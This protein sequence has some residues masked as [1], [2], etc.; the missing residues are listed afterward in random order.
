MR[1][2]TKLAI[3]AAAAAGGL[4]LAATAARAEIVCNQAGDC[5]HVRHHYNYEPSFGLMV[6]PDRWRWRDEDR[7]HYRWREH[8]GRGYWGPNGVWIRF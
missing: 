7:D 2:A 1:L 6:H 3:V 8:S 5:W 4:S